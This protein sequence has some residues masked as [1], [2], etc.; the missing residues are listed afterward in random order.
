MTCWW[1][2]ATAWSWRSSAA[3]GWCSARWHRSG[4]AR[5]QYEYTASGETITSGTFTDCPGLPSQ[6][7]RTIIKTRTSSSLIA[8]VDA[9]A[10]SPAGTVDL[11]WAVYLVNLATGDDYGPTLIASWLS[12]DINRT[13]HGRQIKLTGIPAGRYDAI[14]QWRRAT[15][16]GTPTM[17]TDDRYTFNIREAAPQV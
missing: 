17:N 13:P 2:P 11:Q 1:S 15:G 7:N 10:F 12:G 4:R 5:C 8:R 9:T 6:T 14:M 16:A 3:T